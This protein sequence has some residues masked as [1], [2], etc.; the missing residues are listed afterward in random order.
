MKKF[1]VFATLIVVALCTTTIFTSCNNDDD[2]DNGNGYFEIRATNVIGNTS[3]I[4]TARAVIFDYYDCYK[5]FTVGKAPFQ[6]NGF[7]LRFTNE[8]PASFLSPITKEFPSNLVSDRNARVTT[9]AYSVPF[10]FD[11]SG[12]QIG[13]FGFEN[14]RGNEHFWTFWIYADRDVTIIGTSSG[15][16]FNLN[17]RRG[18]NTIYGHSNYSTD[19]HRV[20]SQRPPNANL[21]WQFFG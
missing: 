20:T 3:G 18:W 21:Q 11:S 2:D 13:F 19:V 16:E 8:V 7:T 10:A 4:A 6:N 14:E 12:N 1:R 15:D 9:F 5:T 17:L